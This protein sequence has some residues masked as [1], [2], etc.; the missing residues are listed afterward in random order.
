M[1][2]NS[3]EYIIKQKSEGKVLAKKL[4]LLGIYA[5]FFG[6][7]ILLIF[8]FSPYELFVPLILIAV[9]L[10]ALLIFITWR[11][12]CV[13]YEVIIEGGEISFTTI[14]GKGFRKRL[15]SLPVISFTEIGEYDDLAYEEISKLSLQKNLIIISSLSAPCVYYALYEDGKDQCI[16]YFDAPQKAVELL[17]KLNS[18]AFRA[19]Q[20]RMTAPK[21][22]QI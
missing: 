17:K 6:I 1:S 3:Y 14:Y 21:G 16:L 10:S 20:K 13:E 7:L 19:S 22:V 18:G 12:T 9:A 4:G 11:Y 15:F 5:A 2:E 8:S